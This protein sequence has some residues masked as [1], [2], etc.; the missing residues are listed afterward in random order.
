MKSAITKE[1]RDAFKDVDLLLTPTTPTPAFKFGEKSD[2]LSMYLAD[3]FTVPGNITGCPSMSVPSGE[4]SG[5]PVGV[6]LTADLGNE[7]VMFEAGKKF[8]S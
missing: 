8:Q 7:E 3:I 1:L 6:L 2:P 5:L 4:V